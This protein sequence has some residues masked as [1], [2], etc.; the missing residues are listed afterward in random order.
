MCVRVFTC[1][2]LVSCSLTIYVHSHDYHQSQDTEVFQHKNSLCYIIVRTRTVPVST[3]HF[4]LFSNLHLCHFKNV[5]KW[6]HLVCN[7]LKLPFKIFPGGSDGKESTCIVGGPGSISGSGRSPGG[8]KGYPLQSSCL[9]NPRDRGA[10]WATIHGVTKS[11]TRLSDYHF[12]SHFF[13]LKQ[14][15]FT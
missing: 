4:I 10:W 15:F 13:I 8:L 9:E 6:N 14:T 12:H 11:Q 7:I 3:S 5:I 1:V 2:C